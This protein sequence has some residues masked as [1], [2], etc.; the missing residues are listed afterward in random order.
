MRWKKLR[1]VKKSKAQSQKGESDIKGELEAIRTAAQ[2]AF[3]T[4]RR[5]WFHTPLEGA[6]ALY[7]KW[8]AVRHSKKNAKQAARLFDIK[9]KK[10]AHPLEVII[11]IVTPRGADK[12]RWVD[13]LLFAYNE[14][15]AP[16]DLVKFLKANGGI[17]GCERQFHAQ[18]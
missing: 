2:K 18:K 15:V 1:K 6:Y 11:K 14:G 9:M 10:G 16:K 8:K 3:D 4:H 13:G 7:D 17:S 5:F 12:R